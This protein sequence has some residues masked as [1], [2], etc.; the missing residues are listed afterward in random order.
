LQ[1]RCGH[2]C[3]RAK[4]WLFALTMKNRPSGK[5]VAVPSEKFEGDPTLTGPPAALVARG[6]NAS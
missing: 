2:F 1:P 5:Y 3:E 6:R 4:Y